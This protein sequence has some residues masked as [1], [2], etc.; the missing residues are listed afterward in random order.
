MESSN[1]NNNTPEAGAQKSNAGRGTASGAAFLIGVV[2]F[3]ITKNA[4]WL[5]IGIAL[6]AA[7][8]TAVGRTREHRSND[9]T[10]S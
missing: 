9:N 7:A 2:L 10:D 1:A 5:A 8:G 6:G 3:A 4:V